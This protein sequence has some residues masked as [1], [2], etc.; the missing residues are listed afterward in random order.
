MKRQLWETAQHIAAAGGA[1][2]TLDQSIID[3]Q[4]LI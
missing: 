3:K 1:N 4:L 2:D